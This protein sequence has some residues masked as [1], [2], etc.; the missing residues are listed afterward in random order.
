MIELDRITKIYPQ[1]RTKALDGVSLEIGSGAF[2]GLLGPNGAGKTT[3]ISIL[4]AV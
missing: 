3:L 1:S 4:C 2:F